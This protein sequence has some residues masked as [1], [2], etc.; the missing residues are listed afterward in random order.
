MMATGSSV[1]LTAYAKLAHDSMSE[2]LSIARLRTQDPNAN[3]RGLPAA[4]RNDLKPPQVFGSRGIEN[5]GQTCYLASIIHFA[6]ACMPF[7][8][9]VTS[10]AFPDQKFDGSLHVRNED[11]SSLLL[12][13]ALRT[14]MLQVK[15]T[16]V[17]KPFHPID[18]ERTLQAI[19]HDW[20]PGI[21]QNAMKAWITLK[22]TLHTCT[23]EDAE[24]E[25]RRGMTWAQR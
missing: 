20:N 9:A 16:G 4:H 7:C 11:A 12:A 22:D 5:L 3:K 14:A 25:C 6:M 24:N 21:Q 23:M 19:K 8:D 18:L 1:T 17:N 2:S 10:T 15:D 13:K